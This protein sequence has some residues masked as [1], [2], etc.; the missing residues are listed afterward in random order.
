MSRTHDALSESAPSS[1]ST[2]FHRL[3]FVLSAPRCGAISFCKRM[4][5]LGGIGLPHTHLPFRNQPETLQRLASPL[6]LYGVD[7]GLIRALSGVIY[8]GFE[9]YQLDA[10]HHDLRVMYSR[11]AFDGTYERFLRNCNSQLYDPSFSMAL[12]PDV[13]SQLE[14]QFPGSQFIYL[15]RDPFFYASSVLTTIHGLDSLLTW[16]SIAREEQPDIVLDPLT[17]WCSINEALLKSKEKHR[18]ASSVRV[19][20]H[21]DAVSRYSFER[22]SQLV[23]SDYVN[24]TPSLNQTTPTKRLSSQ[25]KRRLSMSTRLVELIDIDAERVVSPIQDKTSWWMDIT[26][27][28]DPSANL[29]YYSNPYEIIPE[30]WKQLINDNELTERCDH[31]CMILGFTPLST[32]LKKYE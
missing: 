19:L 30:Y 14:A 31:L 10:A 16:W 22:I 23:R 17:M 7:D 2:D 6:D 20:R 4:G 11:N 24:Y 25:I 1:F 26:L 27:G 3:H 9:T 12:Y 28:G 32:R 8:G 15:F 21:P 13:V 29:S 5:Q 18:T